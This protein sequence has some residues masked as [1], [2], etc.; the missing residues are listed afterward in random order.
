MTGKAMSTQSEPNSHTIQTG[1]NLHAL[2]DLP[3]SMINHSCAANVRLKLNSHGAYD[4]FAAKDIPEGKQIFF[5]YETTENEIQNFNCSCGT[6]ECRGE[7]GGFSKN[8]DVVMKQ[9]GPDM[10]SDYLKTE[11]P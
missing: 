6:A 8:G 9:Y 1:W 3:A 7:L 2:M 4:F 11:K 10:I 5:D